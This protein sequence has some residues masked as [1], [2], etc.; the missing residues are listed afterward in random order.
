MQSARLTP[1]CIISHAFTPAA[2][3]LGC[4]SER[5]S[6]E[7]EQMCT[8]WFLL[9]FLEVRYEKRERYRITTWRMCTGVHRERERER[10]RE[11]GG[12]GGEHE[13]GKSGRDA[14]LWSD[15]NQK[16]HLLH[17]ACACWEGGVHV[18]LFCHWEPVRMC[19]H[20]GYGTV[21]H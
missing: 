1:P 17:V 12:R 2:A 10:E 15:V 3:F 6:S 5:V 8:L 14:W 9:H 20:Q 7:Y 13:G 21:T 16:L 19:E 18:L 4:H 11:R